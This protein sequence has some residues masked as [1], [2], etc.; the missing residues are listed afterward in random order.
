MPKAGDVIE[1]PVTGEKMVFRQTSA[2]TQGQLLQFDMFVE[3]GGFPTTEHIHPSQDEHFRVNAGELRLRSQDQEQLYH[4]GEETTIPAGTPH[5][6]WNSGDSEL[7]ATVELR[8]AGRFASFITSLFALAQDG[9]T[10]KEGMPNLL[11]TAVLMQEY[12]DAIYPSS[13]PRPV[14]KIL[15]AILAP[16]GRALGYRPDHPYPKTKQVE[17]QAHGS[18]RKAEPVHE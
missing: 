13:P 10:N 12:G 16:V 7:H 2:E 6:W 15:F 3:P 4:A 9:K 14:Q 18:G 17:E 11:Q 8:P 1:N 5:I